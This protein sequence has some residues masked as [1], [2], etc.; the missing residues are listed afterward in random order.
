MFNIFN[1]LESRNQNDVDIYYQRANDWLIKNT[2]PNSMAFYPIWS[3]F[4]QMFFFNSHNRY[5]TAFDPT[6]LYEYNPAVYYTWAN[7]AYRG[8]YCLHELPCLEFSPR[9]GIR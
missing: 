9:R 6:F 5:L 2:P 8:V 4:P 7:I 1:V 3:M